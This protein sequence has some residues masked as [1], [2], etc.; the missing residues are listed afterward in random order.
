MNI[1]AKISGI[2][3][4]PLLCRALNTFDFSQ[5]SQALSEDGTFVLNIDEKNKIAVSYWV[6]SKRSRSY[7]YARVY[8]S[9]KFSGKKLT[10]IPIFKDEGLGGDRDFLQWDTISLMSLLGVYVIV[11]YYEDAERNIKYENKI[12]NQRFDIKQ[13]QSEIRKLLSYQSDAL[14]W[15]LEQINKVG[16]FS[17]K[18]LQLYDEISRKLGVKMHSKESAETRIKKLLK[19]KEVFMDMSRELAHNAQKRESVTIQP[20]EKLTGIKAILTIK[21]YLGGYYYFTADEAEI[22]KDNLYLIEAKNSKEGNLPSLSDIKDGLFK[23]ILFTNFED[24]KIDNK[25]Y[26]PMPILKLT[27]KKDFDIKIISNSEKEMLNLLKKEADSNGF[28]IMI[29]NNQYQ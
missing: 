5:L 21:N 20:K 3:Y 27:T 12:T 1:S 29:N 22:N 9:L 26:K 11:S 8:D 15:N 4:T 28:E 6:S 10:I 23:M 19:G 17:K 25:N 18:A 14:H 16:E 7:P 13:V 2:K 24:V